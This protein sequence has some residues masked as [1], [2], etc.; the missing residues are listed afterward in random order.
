[1]RILTSLER[2]HPATPPKV[3]TMGYSVLFHLRQ[4]KFEWTLL[5]LATNTV[6]PVY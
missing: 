2:L 5:L 3:R 4:K 1:M 6:G